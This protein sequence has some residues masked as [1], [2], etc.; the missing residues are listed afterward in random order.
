MSAIPS[1]SPRRT[2]LARNKDVTALVPDFPD[3]KSVV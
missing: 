2:P 3:R 1:R